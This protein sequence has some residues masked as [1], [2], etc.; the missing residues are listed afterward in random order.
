MFCT[1]VTI[2]SFDHLEYA[3]DA[4]PFVPSSTESYRRTRLFGN[5]FPENK[6]RQDKMRE[7]S[8]RRAAFR[9]YGSTEYEPYQHLLLGKRPLVEDSFDDEESPIDHDGYKRRRATALARLQKWQSFI[10]PRFTENGKR[11]EYPLEVVCLRSGLRIDTS[12]SSRLLKLR[13]GIG[14][15][16]M[17]YGIS[18][19]ASVARSLVYRGT[20]RRR[21]LYCPPGTRKSAN[22]S[23]FPEDFFL[24]VAH[25][26][27]DMAAGAAGAAGGNPAGATLALNDA[28]FDYAVGCTCRDFLFKADD[29]SGDSGGAAYGCKHIIF[30]NLCFG[31]NLVYGV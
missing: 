18:V 13:P 24:T 17:R 29:T 2:D 11:C 23:V 6:N 20:Q 3:L 7:G 26:N 27:N 31:K 4:Q 5:Y 14:S 19:G 12:R 15:G 8:G 1:V 21:Y 9:A 25:R 30:Y 16:K 28:D 22:P 10:S